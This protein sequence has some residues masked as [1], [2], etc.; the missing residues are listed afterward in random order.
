MVKQLPNLS[1]SPAAIRRVYI[2][3]A[4][5]PNERR[6]LGIPIMRDRT[7]QALVKLAPE[8]EWEARL[9]PNSYGF[10]PGR[11]PHDAIVG[12]CHDEVHRT[13]CL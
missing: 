3:K 9:E 8:P 7:E 6:P 10:R 4:S 2:L 5:N 13:K 11:S 12:H 1:L